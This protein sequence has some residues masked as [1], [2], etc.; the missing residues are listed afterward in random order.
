MHKCQP[1]PFA[2]PGSN[3][4]LRML[5]RF[6]VIIQRESRA[7]IVHNWIARIRQLVRD[8]EMEDTKATKNMNWKLKC[9]AMSKS[10][11]TK[12]VG[13]VKKCSK[14][15]VWHPLNKYQAW[16]KRKK[17]ISRYALNQQRRTCCC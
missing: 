1:T 2:E 14:E 13:D 5:D 9:E 10:W 16:S 15:C 3:A 17:K 7:F 8:P 11:V 12:T 4:R 6:A